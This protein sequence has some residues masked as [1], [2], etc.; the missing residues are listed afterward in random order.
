MLTFEENLSVYALEISEISSIIFTNFS[1]ILNNN[2]DCYYCG[3]CIRV[4]FTNNIVFENTMIKNCSS[5]SMTPG[6]IILNALSE[7]GKLLILDFFSMGNTLTSL[8]DALFFGVSFYIMGE[9]AVCFY[10]IKCS[11]GLPLFIT[12]KMEF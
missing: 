4:S 2:M 6:I 3:S 1:C 7:L 9:F 10:Q 5:L 8:N 12:L 11:A